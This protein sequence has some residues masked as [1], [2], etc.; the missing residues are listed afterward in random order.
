MTTTLSSNKVKIEAALNA[1]KQATM[2]LANIIDETGYKLSASAPECLVDIEDFAYD[3][4]T[5]VEDELEEL[6]EVI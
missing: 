4:V 1:F 6:P 2:E 3:V 5:F